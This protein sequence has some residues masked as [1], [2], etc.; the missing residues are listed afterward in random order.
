M[1]SLLLCFIMMNVRHHNRNIL[2]TEQ[3]IR[4]KEKTFCGTN[5]CSPQ[6]VE[7]V[8]GRR[9]DFFIFPLFC[10]NL[11]QSKVKK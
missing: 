4:K 10:V 3:I 11:M 6:E 2:G 5:W 1:V 9:S 8:S 7:R